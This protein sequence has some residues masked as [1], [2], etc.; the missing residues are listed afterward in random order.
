MEM[1]R[2]E[3]IIGSAALAPF[4]L[5]PVVARTDSKRGEAKAAIATPALLLN[6]SAFE[7]NVA[8]MAVHAKNAG[9]A[10][11]PHFKVH[12][13]V[14]VA[15]RQIELGAIGISAA[16]VAECELLIRHGLPNV[17]LTSQPAGT[18]KISR[19]VSLAQR[20]A[21]FQLVVDSPE[22]VTDLRDAAR[23]AGAKINL[24]VDVDAGMHRQ[25]VESV[26][27]AVSLGKLI[28]S[29]PSLSLAGI[30]AYSGDAAHT[31]GWSQRQARSQAD[32]ALGLA[33]KDAFHSAGLPVKIMSGGSTGTFNID[34]NTLTELQVGSYV[35][36]DTAYEVIGSR[37]NPEKFNDFEPALTILT[38]AISATR[39]GRVS[40]DAGAKAQ[41]RET[42]RVVGRPDLRVGVTG[43]EYGSLS[44][45]SGVGIALGEQV[46]LVPTKLDMTTSAYDRI[47]VI[48]DD[49]EVSEIW[50]IMGRTGPNQR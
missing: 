45:T 3:V 37:D 14:E 41:I 27:D 30:M 40:V 35:F 34:H 28:A 13:C 47:H 10:L 33:A 36:M 12:K 43:A 42:D 19:V 7:R 22:I 9:I 32:L 21:G 50:K 8:K 38:T 6:K 18:N 23:A 16:T 44:W 4:A 20:Q 46:E 1:T 26:K 49:G 5:Q 29:S 2:R 48:S 15:Q 25:G 39:P 24:L 31:A 17:L 11:R